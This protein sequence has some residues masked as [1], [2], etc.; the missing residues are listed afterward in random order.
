[1]LLFH[2]CPAIT[3]TGNTFIGPY[4][5][6]FDGLDV[7]VSNCTLTVDGPHSF[8][9]VQVLAGG[10]ITHTFVTNGIIVMPTYNVSGEE[11]VLSSNSVTLLNFSNINNATIVVKGAA[12]FLVYSNGVDYTVIP[13]PGMKTGLQLLPGSSIRDYVLVSYQYS[14]P[15]VPTGLTLSVSNN[16]LIEAGGSINVDG[17]GFGAGWGFGHGNAGAYYTGAGGGHGGNGGSGAGGNASPG[18]VYDSPEQPA[19]LGSGGGAGYGPGGAGGG[20]VQ[21]SVGGALLV[22][23]VISADGLAA[24]NSRSGGGSGGSISITAQ[25]IAGTGFISANGGEGESPAGGGG[26][27]GRIS[28][29]SGINIFGGQTTAYGGNG[30]A[31]GGAGTIYNQTGTQPGQ[32]LVD[33]GGNRGLTTMSQGS[34]QSVVTAQGGAMLVFPGYQ[35][36][37]GLVIRSNALLLVTN[38][39]AN[40]L[41]VF[42]D[43]SIEPGGAIMADG[44]GFSANQGPGA[45]G[46][47]QV[48]F[49]TGGGGG[50]GGYGGGAN[51]AGASGGASYGSYI[52]PTDPGSGG[53]NYLGAGFGSAGGG[54]ILLKV[55]GTLT[56]NGSI[57]ANGTVGTADGSG[58]GAG[59]SVFI[60]AGVLGGSGSILANGGDGNGAGLYS[61]GG[62]S[63]GRI[64]VYAND[65]FFGTTSAHGGNGYVCGAAGT[66]YFNSGQTDSQLL[67]DNGGVAGTPTVLNVLSNATL[68]LT[69][70]GG[71]VMQLPSQPVLHNLLV[72][73]TVQW[74]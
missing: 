21:L 70:S 42:G 62:G 26:G 38:T 53:G 40:V 39:G 66:I 52:A 47:S 7:I 71:A 18:L 31:Y 60:I 56:V 4:D 48:P 17:K 30:Y 19:G 54:V 25:T 16:V 24:T 37:A 45:G 28:F 46:A 10:N 12:T 11:H 51:G 36:I 44:F 9:S 1:M 33:N 74:L 14:Q 41:T 67:I 27:G 15:N 6:T 55:T 64:A 59:G 72:R 2:V 49:L 8:A 58:G 57:S 68:D 23:G 73:P 50:Y 63:G 61:G 3:F 13:E 65:W 69:V 35:D 29:Q 22:N 34:G 32:V 5:S 20:V 43:A